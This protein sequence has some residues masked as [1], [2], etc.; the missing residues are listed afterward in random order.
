LKEK[1]EGI[2]ILINPFTG[3]VLRGLN[4]KIICGISVPSARGKVLEFLK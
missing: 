2:L 3:T 4:S 1:P